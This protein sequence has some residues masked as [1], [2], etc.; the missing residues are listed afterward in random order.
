MHPNAP[1]RVAA[2]LDV[3]PFSDTPGDLSWVRCL[4]C[5]KELSLH[6]PDTQ[7]ADRLLGICEGC[8]RWFLI[9]LIPDKAEAT[10]V[11]L[12]GVGFLQGLSGC[13]S[14]PALPR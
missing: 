9:D 4:D 14:P 12:P 1:L 8:K 11:L 2:N 7:A 13:P 10:M 3:I 5:R 6:Q